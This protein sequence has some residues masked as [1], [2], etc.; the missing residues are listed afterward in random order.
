M[1]TPS[2]KPV[3]FAEGFLSFALRYAGRSLWRNKRRTVLTIGTVTLSVFV[4]IVATRYST[5]VLKIWQDGAIDHG[6]GHAQYHAPGYFQNPDVISEQVTLP[7]ANPVSEALA[8]DPAVDSYTRRLIFEG[9]ISSGR[10]TVYFLGR[11]I[12]PETELR[13]SPGIFNP[14]GDEGRFITSEI[15]NGIAIGKG[16]AD[17][18]GLKLGD[19]ATLMTH[20]LTGAVNGIDVKVIGIVNPPMPALSKRLVYMHLEQGQRSIKIPGRFSELVV[21]LKPGIDAEKWVAMARPPAEAAGINLRGW[22]QV[23][24]MIREV[25]RI[26]DSVVGVISVLLFISAGISV[27]NI[28]FMLVMERT[29]EIGT[30]M[31]IGARPRD[32][33]LLFTLEAALI[34]VIGGAIGAVLGNL[35]VL[36]MDLIG[37]PFDSPFGGGKLMV[38]PKISLL[39]TGLVFVAAIVIC[40]ISALAPSRK[41]AHVEPV[42]AFRGQ[43]T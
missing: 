10:K 33:R 39:V 17:T 24:P 36:G 37:V 2:I 15:P 13:V 38:H 4:S 27:L 41:A 12:D 5:A 40:Y 8:K 35:Y 18:L 28:V 42:V 1:S 43:I 29:T 7:D 31:A 16:L 22:W 11:A 19:E 25:E 30:L 32:I 20:T 23:D 34:G 26:W 21:R 9:I 14:Q 6:A 3:G